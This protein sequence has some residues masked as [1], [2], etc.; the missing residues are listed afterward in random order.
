MAEGGDVVTPRLNGVRYFDKPPLLYWLMAAGFS[1]AGVS[2]PAA[3]LWPALGAVGCAAVTAALGMLL[4]GPR[5]GLVAG[6]IVTANLGMFL[7]A[8]LVKPD[9]LF[10]LCTTLALGGFA[11]AYLR[12]RGR[13]G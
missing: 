1:I 11:A 12:R 5:V 10:I 3:R 6:L 13:W 9:L 8:R 2:V 4:G 7:Y